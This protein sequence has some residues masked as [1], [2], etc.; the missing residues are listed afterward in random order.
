M[1]LPSLCAPFYIRRCVN[2]AKTLCSSTGRNLHKITINIYMWM[3]CRVWSNKH[4]GARSCMRNW[5][6]HRW[7]RFFCLYE[8]QT[9]IILPTD[10]CD[11]ESITA[12]TH[13]NILFHCEAPSCYSNMKAW[14]SEATYPLTISV[15]S[16]IW[17]SCIVLY[18]HLLLQ[19]HLVW[20]T[21]CNSSH[22]ITLLFLFYFLFLQ[23]FFFF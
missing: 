12:S 15:R 17:N 22:S 2:Y 16:F 4:R 11:Y 23:G 20:T 21:V 19:Q 18:V 13:F 14:V 7:S 10:P 5:Q 8:L 6:W 1:S 9:S 3:P